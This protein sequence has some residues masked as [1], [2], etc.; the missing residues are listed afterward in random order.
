MTDP[1]TEYESL[2]SRLS[3]TGR[4]VARIERE[5]GSFAVETPSWGYGDSGTRFGV[6][7]QPGRPRDVFE[8]IEDAAEVH[9]L[10]GAAPAV[11]L[12]F[13]W[14]AVEDF[15][16]LR[17]HLRRLGLR[18]G[19][20]NP[21][22]FQDPDYRLGSLTNPDAGIRRKAV[23]HLLECVEIAARSARTAQSLWLADGTNYAGQD[24]SPRAPRA[25]SRTASREL[26]ARLP[27]GQRAARRVQA[28]RAGV[29]RAPTSPTGARRCCCARSSAPRARVLVDLGHHAQGVN[30][31]QIVALLAAEAPARRLSLQQP[32]V[33]RRRPD[34]R[35]GQSVRA[36]PDLRRA[37]ERR[38]ATLPRL[39]IDQSHNIEPKVEAMILSVVNLQEAYAK[40]LLVDRDALAARAARRVTCSPATRSCST[41]TTPTCGRCARRSA[42]ELGAAAD[43]VAE[44]RA[45][46]YAERITAERRAGPGSS[47]RAR[48]R[49]P[50]GPPDERRSP[51]WWRRS[52]IAGRA[53]ARRPTTRSRRSL[54]A[55]HLLGSNRALANYGGGNTS[56]KGVADR[57]RRPRGPGDVGQGLGQRPGDDV[58]VGLHAAAARGDPA[59]VRARGDERRGDGGA[60]SRAASS[61]PAAPRSSIETLLHAFI[62][63]D[64]VHHTHPDAI[65]VLACADGG[66]ELVAECFGEQ[67]VWVR[68][69][70][71]RVHAR[72]AGGRGRPRRSGRCGSSCSPSTAWSPG[73]TTAQEAYERTVGRCNR[74][75][76]FA[77]R[78]AARRAARSA[79]Q[80]SVR[81]ARRRRPRRRC[82]ARCCRRCAARSR[83]GGRRS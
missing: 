32:Q 44:L 9:R 6:F 30:V 35:L 51:R 72:Q 48:R 28:V 36:V 2:T 22:L 79:A 31:E 24:R 66:A 73:A 78:K 60:T 3:D 59:A 33:R 17:D 56:A 75:A 13:P 1:T 16:E 67:A 81:A 11:A 57:P 26:Y 47:G 18:V 19:A 64:H 58:G 29:L 71:S 4:D 68:V 37:G 42:R 76:E 65:N 70:P 50:G 39:T 34:R 83:A 61:I 45:S 82:C 20:I 46:G 40:A 15:G 7:P 21:N 10:T 52:R 25:G 23:D 54:F 62:P 43:P 77:N 55:S 69:H 38:P 5:L 14:D 80:R 49:S 41:P 53:T 63:A 8:K 12:H 74:A 27:A